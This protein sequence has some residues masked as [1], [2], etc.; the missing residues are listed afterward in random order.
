VTTSSQY[1][2]SE[3]G[4]VTALAEVGVESAAA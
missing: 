2:I 3:E 1:W 4:N